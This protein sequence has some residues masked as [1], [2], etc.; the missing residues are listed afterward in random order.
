MAE[1]RQCNT[2]GESWTDSGADICRFC[3]SEDTDIVEDDEETES[4]ASHG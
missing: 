2:C 3:G 4:E 1:I